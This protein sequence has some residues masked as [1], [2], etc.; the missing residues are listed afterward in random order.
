MVQKL[1]ALSS[2]WCWSA[3]LPEWMRKR[4]RERLRGL[5]YYPG[6][7]IR[8]EWHKSSS[9]D[10]NISRNLNGQNNSRAKQWIWNYFFLLQTYFY[11][12]RDKQFSFGMQL[13]KFSVQ[14]Y[15]QS[16]VTNI[17]PD[18]QK[19]RTFLLV[20]MNRIGNLC[21]AVNSH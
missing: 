10:E 17:I 2:C 1:N 13:S 8:V 20:V 9:L 14:I 3:L 12:S 7:V 18:Q 6:K 16:T 19:K 5:L 11:F 15:K 21:E 4:L